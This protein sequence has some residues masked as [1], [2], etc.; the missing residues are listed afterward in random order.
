M[1]ASLR[2]Q[3]AHSSQSQQTS[4]Y[5]AKRPAVFGRAYSIPGNTEEYYLDTA[6]AREVV[7]KLGEEKE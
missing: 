4:H 5:G 1:L 7:S 3:A 6:A 2:E